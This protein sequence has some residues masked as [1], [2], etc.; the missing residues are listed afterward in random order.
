MSGV[1]QVR[2]RTSGGWPATWGLLAVLGAEA[3]SLGLFA[4][5]GWFIASCAIAGA[6]VASTFSF[7]EPSAVVRTLA[8]ARIALGFVQRLF[9]HQG[10]LRQLR[11]E[12]LRFFDALAASTGDS[13]SLR[14]GALL[15]RAMIDA[16]TVSQKRIQ[17]TGPLLCAGVLSVG[18]VALLAGRAPVAGLL[19]AVTVVVSALLVMLRPGAVDAGARRGLTR[20]ELV[21][22]VEAW[23]E[24]AALGAAG[25][26]RRRAVTLTERSDDAAA[27]AD[28][29]RRGAVFA[30]AVVAS[31]GLALVA[32]ALFQAGLDAAELALALLL[33][34]GVLDLVAGAGAGV[35]AAREARQA[36]RRLSEVEDL[37]A[38]RGGVPDATRA[39]VGIRIDGY[40]LPDGREV[41]GAVAAGGLLAVTGPSGSG[42]TTL[43]HA[44]A[45]DDGTRSPAVH[46][47]TTQ[48]Y[49]LVVAHSEPVF[50]GT[51]A[52]NLRLGDQ[53]ID[54]TRAHELLEPFGLGGIEPRTPVGIGGRELSGGEVRRLSLARAVAA[55]P[56]VLLVDE[57]TAGLDAVTAPRTLDALRRLLPETTI[58]LAVHEVPVWLSPDGVIEL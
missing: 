18:A 37:P 25:E 49:A 52:S 5:S 39:A 42:K 29:S 9:Q 23:P 21:A 47:S 24:L 56:D 31:I 51:I 45:G 4:V 48:P 8:L 57:P 38:A 40:H 34:A 11:E 20:A 54:E 7:F 6:A 35:V 22:T 53:S 50:T 30:P 33:T 27:R 55:R 44:I 26:L 13:R 1:R 16:D 19:L 17:A 2:R 10:A 3:A 14:D 58:V 32:F 12:R 28:T 41:S 15:D 43:L 46:L 36:R